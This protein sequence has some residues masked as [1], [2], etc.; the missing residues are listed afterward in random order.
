MEFLEISH[1]IK[2]V[3]EGEVEPHLRSESIPPRVEAGKVQKIVGHSMEEIL[4]E[5]KDV[6]IFFSSL[7]CT[8]CGKHREMYEELAREF[9]EDESLI[10]GTMDL[11][12]NELPP[13]LHFP[14]PK[15]PSIKLFRANRH[16]VDFVGELT[17]SNLRRFVERNRGVVSPASE[18][19]D[20]L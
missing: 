4:S 18:G 3:L 19:R 12:L 2:E 16:P 1:F 14:V 10:V 15:G 7:D 20:E 17:L 11:S 6:L 5:E 8:E 13:Q 9:E